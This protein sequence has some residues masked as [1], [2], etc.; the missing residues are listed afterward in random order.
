VDAGVV[1]EMGPWSTMVRHEDSVSVVEL[2]GVTLPGLVD[3]HNHLRGTSLELQDVLDAPLE[4]W[5]LQLRSLS[6]L[7]WADEARLAAGQLLATGV[8]TVQGVLHD[9]AVPATY[10]ARVGSVVAVLVEAGIRS[11]V[12]VGL[13][14]QAE[15]APP[16]LLDPE[17]EASLRV[18]VGTGADELSGVVHALAG[19]WQG[20]GPGGLVRIG[21]APVAPQ[22]SSDALLRATAQLVSEGVRVHTH[23]LES[24][25]QRRWLPEAPVDRLRRAGLLGPWLSVAH[26]VWLD[27][28]ELAELTAAGVSVVHCPTSNVG[29]EVGAARVRAWWDAGLVPALATD[30]HPREGRLDMFAE[31]RCALETA[32]GFG[33]PLTA[34]QVLAM[35]TQGGAAA[36][37]RSDHL[38]EIGPGRAADLLTLD[39]PVTRSS[40]AVALADAVVAGDRA[41]VAGVH[42]AGRP[43][44]RDGRLETADQVDAAGRRVLAQIEADAEARRRRQTDAAERDARV[45]DALRRAGLPVG[46]GARP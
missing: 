37:G 38:G 21:V 16:G 40:S 5:L 33:A 23:L 31:M 36:V 42:V 1:V 18:A 8:T 32:A 11:D 34:S 43:A 17:T 7:S 15:Y 19:R 2:D 12:M 26:G 20:D 24:P 3:A 39:L 10:V 46:A 4:Q 14:D 35:A 22:W 30:S 6:E 29:L 41:Q 9:A 28:A 13:T 44:V 27:D 25:A 45:L